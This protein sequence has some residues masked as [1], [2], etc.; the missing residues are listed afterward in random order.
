MLILEHTSTLHSLATKTFEEKLHT[1]LRKE[2]LD[3]IFFLKCV[4]ELKYTHKKLRAVLIN[5][6]MAGIKGNILMLREIL[7]SKRT[8][9]GTKEL[10]SPG[11]KAICVLG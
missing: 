3:E 11:R 5:M 4:L 1:L 8:E 9:P 10:D 2:G 6:L 7:L